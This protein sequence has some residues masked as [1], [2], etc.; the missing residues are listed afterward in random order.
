MNVL[1]ALQRNPLINS[2]VKKLRVN[3]DARVDL[4][5]IDIEGSEIEFLR[6]HGVFLERVDAVL[7]E[8]HLWGTM[9]PEAT[10]IL[11]ASHFSLETVCPAEQHAGTAF[12]RRRLG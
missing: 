5:K 10:G 6:A 3:R 1:G 2:L 7:I 4:L 9:L 11:N 12:F 8:W